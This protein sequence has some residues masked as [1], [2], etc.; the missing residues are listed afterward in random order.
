MIS[1][2]KDDAALLEAIADLHGVPQ[3]AYNIRKNGQGLSRRS[4]E[5][6]TIE[7][8]T[9][10]PAGYKHLYKAVHQKRKCAYTR[11]NNPE[12]C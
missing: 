12:R 6:I 2:E 11:D 7:P 4:S 9:G 3:G 1:F 8:K 5:N 10:K